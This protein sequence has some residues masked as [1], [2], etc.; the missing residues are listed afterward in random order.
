MFGRKG[1]SVI[2][3][4]IQKSTTGTDGNELSVCNLVTCVGWEKETESHHQKDW[5][6]E[7][8]EW[9]LTSRTENREREE[10]FSHFPISQAQWKEKGSMNILFGWKEGKNDSMKRMWLG[11]GNWIGLQVVTSSTICFLF[12][13][14]SLEMKSSHVRHSVHWWGFQGSISLKY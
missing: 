14:R 9:I 13:A 4:V 12:H 7:K 5:E 6:R 2:V 8:E 1:R 10:F 11:R 3:S